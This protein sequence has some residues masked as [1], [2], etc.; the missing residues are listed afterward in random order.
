[1]NLI[2]YLERA[3]KKAAISNVDILEE[4]QMKLFGFDAQQLTYVNHKDW[5]KRVDTLIV[6]KS[7]SQFYSIRNSSYEVTYKSSIL[8]FQEILESMEFHESSS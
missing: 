4:K 8:D 6:F 3:K 5:D 2:Q 1:M 7:D